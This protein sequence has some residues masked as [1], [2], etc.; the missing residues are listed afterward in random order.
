MKRLDPVCKLMSPNFS[1]N[2]SRR[3]C[4]EIFESAYFKNKELSK[5][6]HT[7][8]TNFDCYKR[9]VSFRTEKA[10]KESAGKFYKEIVVPCEL[11]LMSSVRHIA[12]YVSR[13]Y[14]RNEV[15]LY[16]VDTSNGVEKMYLEGLINNVGVVD[17]PVGFDDV[18]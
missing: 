11:R 8:W 14:R 13:A 10:I 1:I 16:R 7:P 9:R 4:L 18:E 6:S 12:F 3:L 17:E 15:F 5:Y 2:Q